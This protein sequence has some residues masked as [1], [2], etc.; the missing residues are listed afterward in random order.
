M[1]GFISYLSLGSTI[2]FAQDA[3]AIAGDTSTATAI[4]NGGILNATLNSLQPNDLFIIE[5]SSFAVMGGVQVA[6]LQSVTIQI[7]GTL[8]FSDDIKA[9]PTRS[10]GS[11][12]E[13]LLFTAPKNVTFT[14]SGTGTLDGQG[15]NKNNRLF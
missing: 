13:A 9:W 4:K 1:L 11:V 8:L 14:S 6:N 2:R 7:D 12:L 10:D 3:G 15:G 5:N